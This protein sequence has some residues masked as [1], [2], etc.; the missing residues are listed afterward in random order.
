MKKQNYKPIKIYADQ[1]SNVSSKY[2]FGFNCSLWVTIGKSKGKN[3]YITWTNIQNLFGAW[4][5]QRKGL[6]NE[7]DHLTET[8]TCAQRSETSKLSDMKL[9]TYSNRWP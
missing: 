2:E 7:K 4:E 5:K 3:E 8:M 1:T 9:L 6:N